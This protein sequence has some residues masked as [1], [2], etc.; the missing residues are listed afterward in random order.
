M[1][2]THVS[3]LGS[4]QVENLL[5]KKM[6]DE[7]KLSDSIRKTNLEL[8]GEDPD[9]KGWSLF[10]SLVWKGSSIKERA[11]DASSFCSR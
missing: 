9:E 3:D 8:F 5:A 7:I 10:L 1:K 4:R 2:I 11:C 6:F